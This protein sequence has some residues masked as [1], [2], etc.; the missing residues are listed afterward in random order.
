MSD[1]QGY[2]GAQLLL[3]FLGGA[4]TG[5]ATSRFSRRQSLAA[6]AANRSAATCTRGRKNPNNCR[7][8]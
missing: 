1:R 3:A 2:G 5:A 8:P 6:K 4:A 7:A